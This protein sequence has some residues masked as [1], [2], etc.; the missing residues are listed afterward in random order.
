MRREGFRVVKLGTETSL[1]KAPDSCPCPSSPCLTTGVMWKLI[2]ACICVSVSVYVLAS[3]GRGRKGKGE[4]ENLAESM[5]NEWGWKGMW[6]RFTS[7]CQGGH[8][9][10][11]HP[12]PQKQ[13]LPQ[14]PLHCSLP[15][16][17]CGFPSFPVSAPGLP[18]LYHVLDWSGEVCQINK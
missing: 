13:P 16:S 17:C 8:L 10:L 11:L 1:F 3:R 7:T 9:G 18:R 14:P 12:S 6:I 2:D 5:R 15:H 4:L